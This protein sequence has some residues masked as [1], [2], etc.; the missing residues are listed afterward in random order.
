MKKEQRR[1]LYVA[2]FCASLALW[3]LWPDHI[4]WTP[5][6]PPIPI[7]IWTKPPAAMQAVIQL[8]GLA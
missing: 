5:T 6:I 1:A 2:C 7:P 3:G 4:Y 8:F